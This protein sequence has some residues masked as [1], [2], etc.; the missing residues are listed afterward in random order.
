MGLKIHSLEGFPDDKTRDYYVYLLD[1]GWNEPLGNALRNNFD[2][3]AT[4]SSKQKNSVIVMRTEDGVE[5]NDDVLSWHGIN[6][7]SDPSLLPAVLITN[8]H[9]SIFRKRTMGILTN[10]E[11]GEL[12]LI[13]IPLKRHCNTTGEVIE[14]IQSI[15]R[16]IAVGKELSHFTITE[17][18]RRGKDNAIVDSIIIEPTSDGTSIKLIDL[19]NYLKENVKT[20]GL[21]KSVM[22][23]H[24]EDRSGTEFERLTFAYLLRQKE[25]RTIHWLGQTGGDGGRDIWG[26]TP[27]TTYCYQCA[28]YQSMT[29]AK[30]QDDIDK[31]VSNGTIPEHFFVVCGGVVTNGI[32]QKIINYARANLGDIK[33]VDVWSGVEFEERLYRDTPELVERFVKGEAFPD[34][35]EGLKSFNE[36]L[37]SSSAKNVPYPDGLHSEKI[38]EQL[39]SEH[40]GLINTSKSMDVIGASSFYHWTFLLSL[41]ETSLSVP[42]IYE[43]LRNIYNNKDLRLK[44][45]PIFFDIY[46][47]K[48]SSKEV[49]F[50]QEVEPLPQIKGDFQEQLLQIKASSIHFESAFYSSRK[51]M[52]TN[53]FRGATE[54]FSL[55]LFL[56][57][58]LDQ[59]MFQL[60]IELG[61]FSNIPLYFKTDGSPI[62]ATHVISGFTLDENHF[63]ES[64]TITDAN[65]STLKNIMQQILYGFSCQNPLLGTTDT[66]LSL[67]NPEA[68]MVLD[69]IKGELGIKN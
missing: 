9:P 17:E 4:L 51:E 57:Q 39:K 6:G 2:K 42:T 62:A 40:T 25:W 36:R 66:F 68:D 44:Y 59:K 11:E 46:R 16:Q 37:S 15:F 14:L 49:L 18:K 55:L 22:R 28:N 21:E 5:F 3:F 32:R 41:K 69:Y 38:N 23:I 29:F 47:R 12:K 34:S 13:L 43:G 63:A 35:R 45:L 10:K 33:S 7:D 1:Y 56:N 27:D 24:F 26:E 52:T 48:Q 8:R 61:L 67:N 54:L 65:N 31:L 60:D 20:N 64:I 19:V 30:A 58:Q 53:L 50:K